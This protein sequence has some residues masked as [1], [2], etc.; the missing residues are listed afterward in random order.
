MTWLYREVSEEHIYLRFV[1]I[2]DEHIVNELS[3]CPA[4][5]TMELSCVEGFCRVDVRSLKLKRLRLDRY[6]LLDDGRD[7]TLEIIPPYVK[8]LE[9]SGDLFDLK[10]SLVDVS[11]VVNAKLTF[12]IICI[13][14]IY[15]MAGEAF[16][17]V[18]DGCHDYHQVFMTLVQDY[19]QNLSCAIELT[20]GGSYSVE[21][22]RTNLCLFAIIR[23][24]VMC[25]LQLKGV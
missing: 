22:L 12:N 9:I 20:V 10:R 25:M 4:L 15:A 7:H 18:E 8:E 14:N 11:S 23:Y 17:A 19:L 16:D 1:G 6:S 24:L 21:N 2:R 13:R 3:S 5:E